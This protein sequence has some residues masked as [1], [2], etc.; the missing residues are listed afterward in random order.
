M[1]EAWVVVGC[2]IVTV[3]VIRA[4]GPVA[5]GGRELPARA[6]G[7][8]ALLA[9]ALLAALVV[10][11]TFGGDRGGFTV[12]ERLVGLAGAGAAL[13]LRGGILL[14]MAVSMALTAGARAVIG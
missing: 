14:T 8:V 3:A 6:M 1:A 4:A 13:A 9:P 11:E 2:V 12:D 7:V 5:L 10:T